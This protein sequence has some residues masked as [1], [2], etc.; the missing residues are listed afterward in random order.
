M[1]VSRQ[2]RQ[3]RDR[4]A[5]LLESPDSLER[6]WEALFADFPFI[7]TDCLAL[8]IEPAQLVPCR[9]GRAEADFYFYPREEDPL[10]RYGVIEIK[11]PKT[12]ILNA[13]RKDVVLLSS[14]AATAVAQAQKYAID[15]G[16]EIR[17]MHA[18][19]VVLGGS[20]HIFVIAGMSA[21]IA[22]KVTTGLHSMQ[23]SS[24]LPSNCRLVPFDVLSKSLASRTP[25]LVHVVSP[26][27]PEMD[28]TPGES[29]GFRRPSDFGPREMHPTTCTE[30]EKEIEVPFKPREGMSVY[31]RECFQKT[32]GKK[33][34]A[35]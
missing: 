7:L 21:E 14:D 5:D 16:A 32:R 1:R 17:E 35:F 12:T 22:S 26:W 8:G 20:H 23:I 30:C 10:S 31:C 15:L 13:P 18:E 27:C 4:F 2:L 6:E 3:A 34:R 25:P 24:L 33:R 9:P 11:R 29:G 28:R 19:L